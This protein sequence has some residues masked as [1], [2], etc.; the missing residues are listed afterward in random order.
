[1]FKYSSILLIIF[2]YGCGGRYIS[3][4]PLDIN[5]TEPSL[6][7]I[8]FKA[9]NQD[10]KPIPD[11]TEKDVIIFED[12]KK[13][14]KKNSFLKFK[15][16]DDAKYLTKTIIAID[17]SG[18]V[19]LRDREIIIENLRKLIFDNAIRVDKNNLL[20]LVT[21]DD[22]VQVINYFSNNKRFV[23]KS[24]K[25][26]AKNQG[27]NIS[28]INSILARLTTLLKDKNG[29]DL[30]KTFLILITSN[31]DN[32]FDIS[33]NETVRI[34]KNKTIWIV[35]VGEKIDK[36]ALDAISHER[37]FYIDDF[38][39]LYSPLKSIFS[40]IQKFNKSIYLVEYLS[41]QRNNPRTN[42]HILK[43]KIL[44]NS[45]DNI[46]NKIVAEFSSKG[47]HDSSPKI[48]VETDGD[49]KAGEDI[50]FKAKTIWAY[51]KPF[52]SWK[53]LNPD[54]ASLTINTSD[55]SQAIL[56]F[57]KNAI[58]ETKLIIK[59][60]ANK[61]ITSF[62][63]LLGIYKNKLFDF[64]NGEIPSDFQHIGAGWEIVR[65]RDK[66][67]L[68]S[69]KIKD[70][71]ETAIIWKGIFYASK[72]SFDYKVSSEEGCDELIFLIDGKRF[73]ESGIVDWTHVEFPINSGE[74][75]FQWIYKKDNTT[76]KYQDRAWIDNIQ[77]K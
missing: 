54:L 68:Q 48:V 43:M 42:R 74:H 50:I 21:F 58:G 26:I 11:L 32:S 39:N 22:E 70:N 15:N 69:R 13:I 5:A 77:I 55:T 38:N 9:N 56:N 14:D 72:I 25:K 36:D 3:L 40:K 73:S 24:L 44:N 30:T 29:R 65:Y 31:K 23:L 18:T 52:Y 51:K 27:S 35:G 46:D 62:P 19:S 67:F 49:I 75:T 37:T 4:V 57:S 61:V 76:S 7:N 59:D 17:I 2:F 64:Q 16:G 6:I 60:L 71:E 33:F 34:L 66:F 63:L 20:M 28:T 41:P 12:S 45:N 47:F 8:L 1:M 10:G 53:V